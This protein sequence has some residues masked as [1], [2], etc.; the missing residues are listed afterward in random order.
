[1]G[2]CYSLVVVPNIPD[3]PLKSTFRLWH[4]LSRVCSPGVRSSV[5]RRGRAFTGCLGCFLWLVAL[6]STLSLSLPIRCLLDCLS[7]AHPSG[8]PHSFPY[9]GILLRRWVGSTVGAAILYL[10]SSPDVGGLP[11]VSVGLFIVCLSDPPLTR[12]PRSCGSGGSPLVC[13]HCDSH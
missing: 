9:R 7:R 13:L 2:H 1:M 5:C 12:T 6:A 10:P 3:E 11:S 8:V 4:L